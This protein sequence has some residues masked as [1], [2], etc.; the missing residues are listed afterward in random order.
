MDL[1]IIKTTATAIICGLVLPNALKSAKDPSLSKQE[2]GRYQQH[3][4]KPL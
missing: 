1:H 4:I 3:I 2:I